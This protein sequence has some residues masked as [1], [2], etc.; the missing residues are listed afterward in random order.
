[1]K[2]FIH[3]ILFLSTLLWLNACLEEPD[4]VSSTTNFVNLK[5]YS[6]ENNQPDT[7]TVTRVTIAGSDSILAAD[8]NIIQLTLPLNPIA[9]QST[10]IFDTELGTDTLTL[11]YKVSAR[12]ISEDCGVETIYS[13]LGYAKNDFDSIRFV[14]TI[15]IENVKED[16]QIYN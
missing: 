4:C 5:F 11:T 6:M 16:I 12:L 10:F 14:N 3:P 1:M 9:S 7:L 2:K 8:Q 15:L 13:N